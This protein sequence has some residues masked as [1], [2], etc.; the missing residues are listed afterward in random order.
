MQNI[1]DVDIEE[2]S[3]ELNDILIVI[4]KSGPHSIPREFDH[5]LE[6]L[7]AHF[8]YLTNG[9]QE[10]P[11]E[12]YIPAIEEKEVFYSVTH[13]NDVSDFYGFWAAYFDT[14]VDARIY[15]LKARQTLAGTTLHYGNPTQI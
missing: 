13:A 3:L 10:I 8:V 9:L 1:R 15:D 6:T 4:R 11:N 14:E 7:A 12:I 2:L 5:L